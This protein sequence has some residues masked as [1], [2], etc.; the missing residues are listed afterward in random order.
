VSD[1]DVEVRTA[2]EWHDIGSFDDLE[3]AGHLLA[4]LGG[5]EVGVV[6]DRATNMPVGFRNRCPHHGA[7]LCLGR[8]RQRIGGGPGSYTLEGERVLRCPWHGWEFDLETGVCRDEPTMRASVYP[9]KVVDGR[10]L[11]EA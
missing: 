9:A 8:V 2:R 4:R 1:R 10:V 3:C 11:L 5:R 7:P 6:L